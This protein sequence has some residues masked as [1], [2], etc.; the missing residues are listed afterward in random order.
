[1]LERGWLR[2]LPVSGFWVTPFSTQAQ[3]PGSWLFWGLASTGDLGVVPP[4]ALVSKSFRH[5]LIC[6]H[7]S[8]DGLS[9]ADHISCPITMLTRPFTAQGYDVDNENIKLLRLRNFTISKSLADEDFRGPDAQDKIAALIGVVEPF[10]RPP[11]CPSLL[12]RHL[13]FP[14]RLS[15]PASIGS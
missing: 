6:F 11:S 2:F 7:G 9:P 1:M 10:V 4:G 5:R 12:S 13:A 8:V 14:L 3:P 15:A